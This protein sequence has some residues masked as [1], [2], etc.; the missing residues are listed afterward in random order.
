MKLDFSSE[1]TY[2]LISAVTVIIMISLFAWRVDGE[3]TLIESNLEDRAY[4]IG[5]RVA[6]S[7]SPLVY[8][9]FQKSTDR[10]F[11]TETTSAILD[12]EL[13]PIFVRGIIVYGNFGHIFMGKYK[14][15]TDRLLQT[16]SIDKSVQAL[17]KYKS[18]RVPVKQG[19]MTIGNIEVYYSYGSLRES[20]DQLI[21][22]ELLQMLGLLI[23]ILVL[24]YQVRKTS[25]SRIGAVSALK[26]LERTQGKLM[27]SEQALRKANLTLEDKVNERTAELQETNTKL[28]DATKAADAASKAKSLFLAN[29][30][31]EIRTPMNGVLG[32]TELVLRTDL[33]KE[34][35]DYLEKLKHSS[36]NL[37]HILN[38][39]LDISKIEAGKFTI[40]QKDFGFRELLASLT[41]IAQPRADQ[42]KIELNVNV[43]EPFPDCVVGDAVRFSQVLSNLVS[44]AVKFTQEGSVSVEIWREEGSDRVHAKVSDTGIGITEEQQAHLFSAFSQADASTSRKYGGS[45]LGLVISKH[46]VKLMQGEMRMKS[47]YG[48]GTC[49]EFSVYMPV[50]EHESMAANGQSCD[51]G[52]EPEAKPSFVSSKLAG[53]TC[54]VVEDIEVNRLIAEQLLKQA[55]LEVHC[56][57]NG[58]EA[59]KMARAQQYDLIVMDIQMPEMDGYEAT[60]IIRTYPEYRDIPIVA[61]T[62]NAMSDD[63]EM[64]L[65]AGMNSHLTKPIQFDQVI[66]ELEGFY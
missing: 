58:L 18:L 31:H 21:L 29:M 2:W 50:S 13:E 63:K 56:A 5:K 39:I 6:N 9:M 33:N 30:S 22:S 64:C 28:I 52:G 43:V 37:L 4:G 25:L 44:N 36:K 12:S 59:T 55:G 38:D 11:T 46:L 20:V 62:A 48:K 60:K 54:L 42:K 65:T 34:Q 14:D 41:N 66:K 10:R 35:R 57:V 27:S 40:E 26:A 32:L 19:S 53:K 23:L 8:T 49:V 24:F 15:R 1:R 51:K 17:G 7:V 3:K 45:G 47:H 16:T 61:M